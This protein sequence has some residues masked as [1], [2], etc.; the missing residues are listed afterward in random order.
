M[1]T[2]F[3]Y[4]SSHLLISHYSLASHILRMQTARGK[5]SGWFIQQKSHSFEMKGN[6]NKNAFMQ[7]AMLGTMHNQTK[8]L[9]S[10]SNILLNGCSTSKNYCHLGSFLFFARDDDEEE[11]IRVEYSSLNYTSMS[12]MCRLMVIIT[13]WTQNHELYC[14]GERTEWILRQADKARN[15]LILEMII[16]YIQ[17]WQ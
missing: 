3:A 14:L 15:A 9:Q 13:L 1:K 17:R 16:R 8:H 6:N 10:R 2:L 5:N 7:S 11:T 4:S 12:T